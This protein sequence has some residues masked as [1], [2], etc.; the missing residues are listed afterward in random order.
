[1]RSQRPRPRPSAL[2]P[3]LV[4]FVTA[5]LAWAPDAGAV[6]PLPGDDLLCVDS[7]G[8]WDTCASCAAA[9]CDEPEPDC[10][11]ECVEQCVCPAG[12]PMWE[13]WVG[14]VSADTCDPPPSE[15][16]QRCADSGGVW[17][18]CGSGCGPA[19]CDAPDPGDVCPPVCIAQCQCPAGAPLWEAELGGCVGAEACGGGG[20]DT[21]EP[22]IA[23][24]DIAEPDIAEPDIAEPGTAADA[25]TAAEVEVAGGEDDAPGPTE[26]DAA[27]PAED[28]GGTAETVQTADSGP[29]AEEDAQPG[30]GGGGCEAGHGPRPWPLVVLALLATLAVRRRYPSTSV[31]SSRSRTAPIFSG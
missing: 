16:E 2:T 25:T 27:A 28:P 24:P 29:G 3:A 6:P 7:G 31:S 15:D 30:G 12:A 10:P 20:G 14:C 4:A 8:F 9:T 13:A 19:T 21:A 23:E 22:D 26:E 5:A 1:M 11:A 18:G 17:T